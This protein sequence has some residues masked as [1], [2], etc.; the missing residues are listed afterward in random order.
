MP[1]PLCLG[2]YMFESLNFGYST[3]GRDLSTP[4]GDVEI[5]GGFNRLQW[6]GPTSDAVEISGVIFP[7]EFG[8]LSTLEAIR[9]A[10][11]SGLVLPLITLSGTVYGNHQIEGVRD[12]QEYID[13]FG[14]PR[15]DTYRLMLRYDPDD[16]AGSPISI[17]TTIFG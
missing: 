15:K 10:A 13:A 7:E 9:A 14:M 3:L 17:V 12:D 2:P 1:V 8:G 4:S 16:S 5:S 11:I 6:G